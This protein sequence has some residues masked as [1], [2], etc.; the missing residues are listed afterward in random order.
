MQ[1][2]SHVNCTI[3]IHQRTQISSY[4]MKYLFS[5]Q[6]GRQAYTQA[7]IKE[8]GGM[9]IVT[10]TRRFGNESIGETFFYTIMLI[11]CF[12]HLHKSNIS[13]NSRFNISWLSI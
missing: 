13:Q 10:N 11:Q 2:V 5:W 4:K 7:E 9:L 3:S 8:D 12:K 1:H 6:E